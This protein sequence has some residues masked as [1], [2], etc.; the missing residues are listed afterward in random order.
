M[1]NLFDLVSFEPIKEELD[2]L[3]Q[4]EID[5][6]F[7]ATKDQLDSIRFQQKYWHTVI[8]GKFHLEEFVKTIEF[9][10]AELAKLKEQRAV[11]L[12]ACDA[13]LASNV[14]LQRAVHGE[15]KNGPAEDM[16]V[17]AIAKARGKNEWL[18]C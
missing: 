9:Q 10:S 15:I 14:Q 8:T 18:R 3:R 5:L 16:A 6:P 13:L 7:D 17:A 4:A 12:E 2:R 1:K 11:L